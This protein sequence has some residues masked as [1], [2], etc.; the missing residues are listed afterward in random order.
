M[1][2]NL[3]KNISGH[4][5]TVP[6]GRTLAWR[7]TNVWICTGQ[8]TWPNNYKPQVEEC[9]AISFLAYW[10]LPREVYLCICLSVC[11][12]DTELQSYTGTEQKLV[13][14]G[15]PPSAERREWRCVWWGKV[16][17]NGH[18]KHGEEEWSPSSHKMLIEF[19][20]L[21]GLFLNVYLSEL[22]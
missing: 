3:Y 8:D 4:L 21:L 14:P 6:P 13:G 18:K 16:K 20:K 7:P 2:R 22:L 12:S 9:Q 19:F 1:M 17:E 11:A 5:V 10:R 15:T